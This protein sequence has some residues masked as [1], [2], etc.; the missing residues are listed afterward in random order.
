MATT[1][2]QNEETTTMN[3]HNDVQ[4]NGVRYRAGQGVKV[5]KSQA[6]DISRIDYDHQKYKENLMKKNTYEVD[7]GTMAVGGGA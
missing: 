3:L 2:P 5:P 7:S 1:N 4:V 6:D